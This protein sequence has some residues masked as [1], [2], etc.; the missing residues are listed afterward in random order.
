MAPILCAPHIALGR[1]M[2]VEFALA[3]S[4]L[5]ALDALVNDVLS[6]GHINITNMMGCEQ[7]TARLE[8]FVVGRGSETKDTCGPSELQ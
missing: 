6:A 3:R 4:V 2:F 7:V 8:L 1:C 5:D